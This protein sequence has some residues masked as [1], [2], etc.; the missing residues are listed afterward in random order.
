M[1]YNGIK[2]RLGGDSMCDVAYFTLEPK[3]FQT[4]MS[5]G[6][7]VLREVQGRSGTECYRL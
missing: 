1:W 2:I 5:N 7:M 4:R 6:K 3:G